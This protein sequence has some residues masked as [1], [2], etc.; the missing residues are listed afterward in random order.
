[1]KAKYEKRTC[2][3][4]GKKFSPT[5]PKRE[6]CIECHLA[7][8]DAQRIKEGPAKIDHT[9]KGIPKPLNVK[10]G[11]VIRKCFDDRLTDGFDIMEGRYQ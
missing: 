7:A 2:P 8:K 4:C 9:V 11:R 10:G 6:L 5:D 1:M 3:S